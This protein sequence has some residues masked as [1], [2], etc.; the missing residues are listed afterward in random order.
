MPKKLKY[1]QFSD[2]EVSKEMEKRLAE[3]KQL[4]TEIRDLLKAAGE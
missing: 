1:L 3:M 4:L 2:E